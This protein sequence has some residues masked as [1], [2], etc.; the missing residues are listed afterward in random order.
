MPYLVAADLPTVPAGERFRALLERPGILQLPGAHNGMAALQA[1][2]AG[3]DARLSLRRGHDG[4]DGPA[5]SRHH[6]GRRGLLLHPPDRARLGPAA[7]GRRRHRLRRGA[8]RHAHGARLRGGGRRRGPYRGP[9][10]AQEM[11][12]SE[13]QEAGRPARHGGQGRRRRQGAPASLHRRPHRRGGERRHRRRRGAR[14]ALSRGRRRR[15]LPRGAHQ[16]RDVPR[17]RQGDAG[18]D[19]AGQHDGVR[20]HAVLH[21]GR[22]RGDGLQDGDLAGLL[23]AGRQQGAGEALCGAPARRRHAE[24]AG[25]DADARRALRH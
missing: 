8:E 6:H 19:A 15:D 23:A 18:R 13:Q 14:Q 1:R 3:F 21:R 12:P 4:L 22:V 10:P 25:R 20:P 7:A 9:D 17:L 11:R 16:R 24:H 5:R 2:A